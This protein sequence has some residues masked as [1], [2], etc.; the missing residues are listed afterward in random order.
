MIWKKLFGRGSEPIDEATSNSHE[1]PNQEESFDE[2]DKVLSDA[3]DWLDQTTVR[4]QAEGLGSFERFDV[5]LAKGR[6][7]FS[8][9]GGTTQLFRCSAVGT[10]NPTKG[11]FRWAWDHPSIPVGA[12]GAALAAKAFGEVHD[13]SAFT[14]R[15]IEADE[16]DAWQFT[17]I[18]GLLSDAV[19]SYRCPGETNSVYL[20]LYGEH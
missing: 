12:A 16:H 11:S 9:S 7:V 19:G 1:L 2:A 15:E 14:H 13:L 8:S 4:L 18:A 3:L 5:D 10:H 20:V 17:G 6:I